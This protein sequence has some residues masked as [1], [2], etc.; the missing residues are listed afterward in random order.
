MDDWQTVPVVGIYQWLAALGP[1]KTVLRFHVI[2]DNV[3]NIL[4]IPFPTTINPQIK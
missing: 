3:P 1:I 4:G 2:D